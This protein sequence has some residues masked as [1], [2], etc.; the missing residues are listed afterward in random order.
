MDALDLRPQGRRRR[1]DKR[2]FRVSDDRAKRDRRADSC[3]GHARHSD[4]ARGNR[5]VAQSAG[6]GC[7]AVTAPAAGRCAA[8]R[9]ARAETGR[10]TRMS[11]EMPWAAI[12]SLAMICQVYGEC[13]SRLVLS[14]RSLNFVA[15]FA[16]SGSI[17]TPVRITRRPRSRRSSSDGVLGHRATRSAAAR[18]ARIAGA[19][20]RR[21]F[22]RV[23]AAPI[24][25][26]HPSRPIA[27]RQFTH[28]RSDR[29]SANC[30]RSIRR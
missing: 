26:F 16:G 27:C 28:R 3:Q 4:N 1:D 10:R 19:R 17:A 8:D 6:P 25:G 18:A 5:N 2:H 7:F 15:G 12:V 9:G 20:A 23:G 13:A 11:N 29:P 22:I 24:S 30:P 14:Q 21:Q